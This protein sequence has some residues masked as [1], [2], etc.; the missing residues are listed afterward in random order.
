MRHITQAGL[1]LIKSFEAFSEYHYTCLAGYET[2]GWGH[3]ILDNETINEPLSEEDGEFLLR[4]D[5]EKAEKAVL[6]NIKVPLEDYQFDALVS[7]T[8]NCGPGAIQ[9]S[10]LRMKLNRQ[11]YDMGEE[12]LKWNKIKGKISKGLTRRRI[13]EAEMFEG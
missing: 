4:K 5:V 6:R 2:V 1:D 12:F 9:R 10:T 13:A 3:V 11:E 8:F 7:F